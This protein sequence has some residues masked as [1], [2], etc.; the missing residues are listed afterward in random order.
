M[1]H[2]SSIP[3]TSENKEALQAFLFSSTKKTQ[4]RGQALGVVALPIAGDQAAGLFEI[5]RGAG[6]DE[7]KPK[8]PVARGPG[9]LRGAWLFRRNTLGHSGI[10]FGGEIRLDPQTQHLRTWGYS[11]VRGTG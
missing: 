9:L 6:A 8:A 11:Q 5:K 7:P 4:Q 10:R 1:S 2:A 3:I